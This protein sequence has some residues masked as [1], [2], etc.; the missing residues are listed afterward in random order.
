MDGDGVNDVMIVDPD[1]GIVR[2]LTS[3][4]GYTSEDSRTLGSSYMEVL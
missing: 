3:S 2:W 1:Q 4:T